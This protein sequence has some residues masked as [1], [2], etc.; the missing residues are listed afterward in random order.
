MGTRSLTY[1]YDDNND[2]II[3]MY[4]QFDG[5][6]TGHGSELADFLTPFKIIQENSYFQESELVFKNGQPRD[7]PFFISYKESWEGY[8][9]Y[10]VGNNM[11]FSKKKQSIRIAA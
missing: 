7:C 9:P 3:C 8:L 2:P 5:Y 4:R 6:P 1:V 11:I 10:W